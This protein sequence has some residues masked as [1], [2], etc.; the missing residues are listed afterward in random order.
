MAIDQLQVQGFMSHFS[1]SKHNYGEHV[2]GEIDS[3]TKKEKGKSQTITN[4][5][6]TIENYRNH[7]EGKK[8]LGVIPIKEGDNKCIFA[9]ID[10]DI[11]GIDYSL[12][13]RAIENNNLPLVPFRSKSGGLH[14]Y[15]FFSEP[16]LAKKTVDFM[17]RISF[18]LSI[19]IL[20]Q[21]KKNS[22]VEIFPKQTKLTSEQYGSW[23]N[24]PYYNAND[25]KTPAIVNGKVLSLT[26]AL[27]YIKQKKINLTDAEEILNNLS[28]FD[29]PPC[30]Q[31]LNL[32]NIL[33]KD[34]GRNNYLFSFGIY[35]KKKDES[36]FEQNLKDINYEL[37][38]PLPE[39]EIDQTIISSLKKRDYVYKCKEHPLIDFCNKKVCKKRE[40]GVGKDGG[41]FSSV[42]C[43]KLYQF[44]TSQPYYEWEV[45]LQGQETFVKLRFK[46]EEEIIRQDAFLK[47]CMRELY[48]LPSKL[49]QSEW[50]IKVNQA[51]KEI[52]I[53]NVNEDEDVSEYTLLKNLVIEFLTSR[54]MAEKR[55]QILV[56]R[57]YYDVQLKLYYFRVKDLSEYIFVQKGFRYFNPRELHGILK[58]WGCQYKVLKT[59]SGKTVRVAFFHQDELKVSLEDKEIFV[60]DF[61]KYQ[62][63]DF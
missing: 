25:T 63:S 41:Y 60:P 10:I 23:I 29:A 47:L 26:D 61:S 42:E 50:F 2:Y 55:D 1:G 54:A 19:D 36:F 38:Q 46:S 56:K 28:Y 8:G 18:L 62:D 22:L 24:L 12:Y 37:T 58:E 14:I 4:K 53:V 9:V 27:M 35:L 17:K 31:R 40:Y 34:S 43:G 59:E 51:L 21:T 49:K 16:V 7:L 5:L 13:I 48:E 45:K 57:V 3:S 11:Y 33:D 39:K 15:A 6:I 20:V 30:L 32:L 52:E 44:K